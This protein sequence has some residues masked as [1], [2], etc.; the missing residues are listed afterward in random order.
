M[1]DLNRRTFLGTATAASL[2]SGLYSAS[3][4]AQE[5]KKRLPV[6]M[7][8]MG[9]NGRGKQ[10]IK[11]FAEFDHVEFAYICEPDENVI[12][13]AVKMITSAGRPEPKVVKDF[14][15]ALEDPNV[16][17]LVI[18][19]PDHWHALATV[20]ACQA[21]K[22][23]YCEKPASH[24]IIEGRRAVDAAR[25]YQRVVGC[26]TQRRS[27]ADFHKAVEIVKSGRLGDVNMARCW[28]NST[29]P[30]IGYEDPIAP[31]SNLDFDLWAGP[32]PIDEY[33]KNLVHYHWH[34]RW[35]FGTGECGNNGI[36]ALDIARWGMGMDS[37]EI[38]SCGGGKYF[39][40][41]DQE[42]PDTQLAQFDFKDGVIQW[43]HRTWCRRGIEDSTFGIAFYGSE[44]SM[45]LGSG[46][47]KI[48]NKA[49]K[50]I[51]SEP[52]A[53]RELAH[54]GNFLDCLESRERP[55]ADI[56]VCH[57]STNLCHLANIAYRT[58]STLRWDGE[59]E[60]FL[61]NPEANKLLGRDYRKGYEL[62]EV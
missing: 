32:G 22:D 25:K 48:Y 57:K 21:G 60:E 18:A 51:E 20:M 53:E 40:D 30:N 1:S 46:G 6:R 2:A 31:P 15:V 35:A 52:A 38:I 59:K 39:F 47:Y 44:G 37:P 33:K 49:D 29:R 54:L 16:D 58:R 4:A 36:H 28:I 41:D 12:P 45:I 11:G 42:T 14:R 55:N 13:S 17:V 19:A 26:G 24:N 34:W 10:L 61:D 7:A 56:E 62:S 5:E 23:V 9:V 27:G 8:I 3:S 43:E 50:E